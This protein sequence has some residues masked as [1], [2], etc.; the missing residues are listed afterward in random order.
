[1]STE[2]NQS[3]MITKDLVN[4]GLPKLYEQGILVIFMA[5]VIW[6]LWGNLGS[7]QRELIDYLKQDQ[8]EMIEVI[9]RNTTAFEN[10]VAKRN[11]Q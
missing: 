2:Q 11:H 5:M 6:A 9:K 8:K 7:S 1:M 10:Y 3:E 4:K